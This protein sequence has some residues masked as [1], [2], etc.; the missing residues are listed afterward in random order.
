MAGQ[1]CVAKIGDWGN[2]QTC[3]V[4]YDVHSAH[5]LVMISR[6]SLCT[7]LLLL[8]FNISIVMMC[9]VCTHSSKLVT[10]VCNDQPVFLVFVYILTSFDQ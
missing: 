5:T 1:E 3:A 10:G 7:Y 2:G 9:T 4:G 6:S 8:N